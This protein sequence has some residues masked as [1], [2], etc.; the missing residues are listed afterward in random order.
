MSSQTTLRRG[1]WR[2]ARTNK[3]VPLATAWGTRNMTRVAQYEGLGGNRKEKSWDKS[4]SLHTCCASKVSWRHKR[5]CP[6][7]AQTEVKYGTN[8]K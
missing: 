6:N 4:R 7:K 1:F 5:G 2:T 3:G 8:A